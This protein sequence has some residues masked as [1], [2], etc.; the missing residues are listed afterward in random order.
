MLRSP[1]IT[2]QHTSSVINKY[3]FL[4]SVKYFEWPVRHEPNL[5]YLQTICGVS[6]KQR[7]S[8]K[9]QSNHLI[10]QLWCHGNIIIYEKRG[11][12]KCEYNKLKMEIMYVDFQLHLPKNCKIQLPIDPVV[13]SLFS[14]WLNICIWKIIRT[15]NK[16]LS[17]T[18]HS[19]QNN[20]PMGAGE[21][22]KVLLTLVSRK[23]TVKR[24]DHLDETL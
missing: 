10:I 24:G 22:E 15:F 1:P 11:K 21:L 12:N 23:E 18:V 16:Y 9:P 7:L 2:E 14:D 17:C 5:G 20:F 19:I 8:S 4:V 3:I 13:L 6:V